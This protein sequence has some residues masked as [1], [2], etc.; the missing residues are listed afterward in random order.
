[1][2]LVHFTGTIYDEFEF[3]FTI[4]HEKCGGCKLMILN[5]VSPY[6]IQNLEICLS[7]F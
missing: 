3:L 1:M 4:F 6:H 2:I 7:N 5:V